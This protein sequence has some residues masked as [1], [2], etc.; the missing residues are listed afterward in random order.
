LLHI[1]LVVWFPVALPTREVFSVK[2]IALVSLWCALL[3]SLAAGDSIPSYVLYEFP[4]YGNKIAGSEK[5]T[6]VNVSGFG[7]TE[8]EYQFQTQIAAAI[9]VQAKGCLPNSYAVTVRVLGYNQPGQ[10]C[11]QTGPD[12]VPPDDETPPPDMDPRS[13]TCSARVDGFCCQRLQWVPTY[14]PT[15]GSCGNGFCD[16]EDTGANCPSDCPWGVTAFPTPT[17]TPTPAP[18]SSTPMPTPT[19]TPAPSPTPAP[20]PMPT[21]MCGDGMCQ[22]GENPMNCPAD[23]HY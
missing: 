5:S 6:S 8:T 11:V 20:T 12:Y 16:G 18:P 19:P 22:S 21:Q 14:T 7:K 17:P 9:Q 13:Y 3:P 15:P 23:C 1:S 10:T 4:C 2:K